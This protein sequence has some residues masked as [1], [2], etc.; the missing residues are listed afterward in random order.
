MFIPGYV[1]GMI[2]TLAAE[3]TVE[4]QPNEMSLEVSAVETE[5]IEEYV[6]EWFADEP[7]HFESKGDQTFLVVGE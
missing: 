7:V 6:D 1:L 3:E 2:T 5:R 4:N